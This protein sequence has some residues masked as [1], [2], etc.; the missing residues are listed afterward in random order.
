MR[1]R[2]NAQRSGSR[3]ESAEQKRQQAGGSQSARRAQKGGPAALPATTEQQKNLELRQ[4]FF[5][6]VEHL[7]ELLRNQTD[8]TTSALAQAKPR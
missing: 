7:K 5:S 3:Y 4:L 2:K 8:A 6:V 1:I